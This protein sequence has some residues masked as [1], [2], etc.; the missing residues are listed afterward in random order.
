MAN[1]VLKGI[2]QSGLVKA[3]EV[4][5][6]DKS[7]E[8]R[9]LMRREYAVEITED[10]AR[11]V[12]SCDVV[13]LAVKPQDMDELLTSLKDSFAARHL[14]ISIAAGRKLDFLRRACGDAPRLVRVMPNLPL[15]AGEGM[16][17][18]CLADPEQEEDRRLTARIFGSAGA[19][20]EMSED[21]FDAV[22]A[23]SGSG[24][25]FVAYLLKA[26]VD[27]AVEQG[28]AVP[29]ARLLAEQTMIG[30]AVY[31]QELGRDID[32]FIQAVCSPGGTTEA[33]MRVLKSS[34]TNQVL[35]KT[36]AAA[37]KRSSE[38]NG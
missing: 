15:M 17:V 26:L 36:L 35:R 14:L 1:A 4:T 23:L 3:D 37:A 38:L 30:T 27:G 25:A 19:V 32:G 16:S 10:A 24:P 29:E 31:L 34:D 9:D 5:A 20:L 33:G 7:A 18:F 2:L 13:V 28:V 12:D 11:L 6:C 22:T 8:R 21:H